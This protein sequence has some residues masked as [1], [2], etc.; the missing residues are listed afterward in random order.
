MFLGKVEVYEKSE[1]LEIYLEIK[2]SS[3]II[4][5]FSWNKSLNRG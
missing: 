4:Y 3:E 1:F 2:E 5:Y